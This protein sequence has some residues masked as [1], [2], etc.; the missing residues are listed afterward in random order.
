MAESDTLY[1]TPT[2]HDY[3]KYGGTV[4]GG[5]GLSGLSTA[6]SRHHW[7]DISVLDSGE[8]TLRRNAHFENFRLMSLDVR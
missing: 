7:L 8:S 1:E 2:R 6:T 5:G 3:V 4:V